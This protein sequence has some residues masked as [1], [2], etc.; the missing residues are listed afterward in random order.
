[1]RKG[2]HAL[3]SQGGRESQGFLPQSLGPART[4]SE[5]P[6][7]SFSPRPAATTSSEQTPPPP[8]P[9]AISPSEHSC[10]GVYHQ[11]GR[12]LRPLGSRSVNRRQKGGVCANAP[13]GVSETCVLCNY[14]PGG[15]Q[16]QT[17]PRGNSNQSQQPLKS[18]LSEG[19][20]DCFSPA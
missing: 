14:V 12:F 1:M 3:E 7:F 6:S 19:T 15:A 11:Q 18:L 5:D 4:C 13:K 9:A 8:R 17:P 20:C 10:L 2:P 16:G